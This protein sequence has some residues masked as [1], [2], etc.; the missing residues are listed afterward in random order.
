MASNIDETK[1]A[2]GNA[3]TLSVRDN[4]AT[5]KSE[6]SELQIQAAAA[7]SI[8]DFEESYNASSINF[9]GDNV[10]TVAAQLTVPAGK[11]DIEIGIY[12]ARAGAT[13]TQVFA[14]LSTTSSNDG[15]GMAAPLNTVYPSNTADSAT[16]GKSVRVDLAVQT[17]LY[18]KAYARYSSGQPQ[19]RCYMARRKATALP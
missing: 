15:T 9:A 13:V 17:T 19:Y 5:A 2:E 6:I 12:F 11:H 10:F 18:L 7:E 4:F 14:G 1:P 8:G 3:T 16:A